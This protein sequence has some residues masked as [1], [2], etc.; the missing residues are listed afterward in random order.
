MRAI[1]WCSEDMNAPAKSPV[2]RNVTAATATDGA[3]ALAMSASP[4]PASVASIAQPLARPRR[5]PTVEPTPKAQTSSA[6]PAPPASSSWRASSGSATFIIEKASVV[7]TPAP[8]T[9]PRPGTPRG[10]CAGRRGRRG[11]RPARP[12]RRRRR[13]SAA[14]ARR[15]RSIGRRPSTIAESRNV[16]ALTSSRS[17]GETTTSSPAPSA[18]ADHAGGRPAGDERAHRAVGVLA[19]EA[20]QRRLRGRLVERAADARDEREADDRAAASRRRRA[21]RRRRSAAGRR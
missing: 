20:G 19:G 5:A 8:T 4:P 6:K 21:R 16:A 11:R 12:L 10:R 14:T 9:T 2:T 7:A 15:A 3:S 17:A 13:P 1:I 18:G